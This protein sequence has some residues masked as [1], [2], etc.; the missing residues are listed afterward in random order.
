MDT[1]QARRMG[2]VGSWTQQHAAAIPPHWVDAHLTG[3]HAFEL[4]PR[5]RPSAFSQVSE[6]S[7]R[8]LPRCSTQGTIAVGDSPL[9]FTG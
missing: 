3:F 7:S 6:Q 1:A 2:E 4:Q 5:A 8:L 9:I